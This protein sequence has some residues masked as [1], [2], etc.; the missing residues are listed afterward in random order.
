MSGII[1]HAPPAVAADFTMPVLLGDETLRRPPRTSS[2]SLRSLASVQKNNAP[3]LGGFARRTLGIILLLVTVV[4]WTTSSFLASV[5]VMAIG[6]R[7]DS[8]ADCFGYVQTIF[9]DN[10]YSKPFLVTY[11]NTSFFAISLIPI[12]IKTVYDRRRSGLP[13]RAILPWESICT[14]YSQIS[15]EDGDSFPKPD[16]QNDSMRHSSRSAS[17]QL[18]LDESLGNSRV[19]DVA[20]ESFTGTALSVWETAKLSLEFC[21][22]WVS[23]HSNLT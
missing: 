11:I 21:I 1:P 8:I 3:T 10:T 9:A 19:L 4:L 23:E 13:L 14:S 18:L 5:R 20:E 22:L 7:C 6:S 12:I 2:S 16:N 17:H 15:G